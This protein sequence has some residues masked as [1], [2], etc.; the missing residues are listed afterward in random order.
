[1]FESTLPSSLAMRLSRRELHVQHNTEELPLRAQH[2]IPIDDLPPTA[3]A[4][5]E[6]LRDELLAIFGYDLVGVWV[7]G[8]TTFADRPDVTGDLDI[9]AVVA[10]LTSEERDPDRWLNDP[11][12]RPSRVAAAQLAVEREHDRDIDATYLLLEEMGRHDRPGGAFFESRRHNT[13]PI[14][15]AHW[16]A[17]QYV[18]LHG[19][20][21]TE[22][23]V[24]PTEQDLRRALSRELEHLERHVYEGDASD[25]Y[26][27]TYAIWTGCRILHALETGSPVI[28]KRSAGAWG[29]ARLSERW[30]PAIDAA[31]RAYDGVAT[32][33][34]NEL[35]RETMPAFV[36]MVRERLPLTKPCPPGEPPRWS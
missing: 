35:L 36:E 27:A 20:R 11:R 33:E 7:D 16:L 12:S 6:D 10:N 22:L 9:T 28:S 30:H 23:V 3:A 24:P 15:R 13:W 4:A 17:G 5:A 29:L 25:P 34:D 32:D 18:H 2:G 8:G 19:R 26:E 31:G 21:P 1:M 14:V